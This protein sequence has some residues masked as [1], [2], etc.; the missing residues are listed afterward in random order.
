MWI[1]TDCGFFSVV[2]KPEDVATGQ[3]TVRARVRAH[4]D[5]LRQ[6][7]LPELGP[8][9]D[10]GGTDYPFRAKVGKPAFAKAMARIGEAIDYDNV[11]SAI[12]KR[13][14]DELAHAL[15]KVWQIMQQLE[16]GAAPPK[17]SRPAAQSGKG[18]PAPQPVATNRSY[19]GVVFDEAGRVLLVKPR[20]SFGG[21]AWTFPKGRPE[22]GETDQDAALRE[23]LEET[24]HAA[25][26]VGRLEQEFAGSTSTKA[27][28]FVMQ[29]V[30][31]SVAPTDTETEAVA[32]STAEEALARIA[33][34]KHAVGRERDA[35]VLRAAL[36]WRAASH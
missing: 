2:R 7:H 11:K 19:G 21:Y 18:A 15:G 4:L 8:T 12:R 33:E 5:A 27:I 20:N 35:K 30:G 32:W 25:R 22:S 29:A 10:G 1:V 23:V 3:L 36:A 31:E 13:Q 17:P 24:G 16:P 14:G 9:Q 26:I 34:T 28:Y 6:R